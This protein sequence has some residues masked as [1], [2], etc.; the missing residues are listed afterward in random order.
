METFDPNAKECIIE[1]Y[2]KQISVFSDD[3]V[4]MRGNHSGKRRFGTTSYKGY[5]YIVVWEAKCEH[6]HIVYIHRLV[7]EAFVPNPENKP[8]VN[9]INGIKTDNHF[10]NLEWVT[11]DENMWHKAHILKSF[12][13]MTP[14]LCIETNQIYETVSEAARQTN[15]NRSSIIR[16]FKNSN[17]TANGYHWKSMK[18]GD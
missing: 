5:K 18:E 1:K 14:V 4:W 2:G 11:N 16:C 17:Y 10:E 13:F 12:S 3:S 6:E 15:T 9:H 7:A 8:Q